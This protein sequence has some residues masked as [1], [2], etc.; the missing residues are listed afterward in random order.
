M[1]NAP[2]TAKHHIIALATNSGRGAL[3]AL[4]RFHPPGVVSLPA[5]PAIVDHS[6]IVLLKLSRS[7]LSL[8]ALSHNT[9]GGNPLQLAAL[10]L[11]ST[12][13]S[14]QQTSSDAPC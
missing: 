5:G 13:A 7:R 10:R 3:A 4:D 14:S 6:H 1:H 2:K 8:A 9:T 12:M 11:S